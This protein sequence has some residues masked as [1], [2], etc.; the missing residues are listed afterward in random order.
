[1][2]FLDG[3]QWKDALISGSN[4][5]SNAKERING[6]NVFPVPD[7]D[8]GSNMSSTVESAVGN[9]KSLTTESIGKIAS[10]F[11]RGALLGARGN[12]GVILSQVF[13]GFS[14]AFQ[15]KEKINSIDLAKAFQFAKKYGYGSVIKPVEGTVL[16]VVKDLSEELKNTI[17]LGNNIEYTFEKIV[18]IAQKSV[19]NT[20]NL[21][22]IL[23]EVGVVDSGGE[24]LLV[25]L[26]GVLSYV[27]GSPV[28]LQQ[29]NQ[30]KK[31]S[32]L[33]LLKENEEFKQGEFGYCTEF[34]VD[35]KNPKSFDKSKF[36]QG[37]EKMKSTS[38]VIVTDEN[39]LKTHNHTKTPGKV[40][41]FAQR[42]GE[43]IKIKSE[44]MTLQANESNSLN[45]NDEVQIKENEEE[46]IEKL[47]FAVI[48]C[49]IGNGI[50]SEMKDLGS[51]FVIE[52][53]QTN[54][55]SPK[56]FISAIEK[57]KAEKIIILPNN[58]NI[59]LAAQQV[60][61]TIKNKQI[62]IIPSRTQ[63]EG[64]VSLMSFNQENSFE[65][66][67]FN[68]NEAIENVQNGQITKSLKTT[69]IRG[70]KVYEGEYLA[71]A[72]GKILGSCKSKIESVIKICDELISEDSEIISIYFGDKTTK[73][74]AEEIATYVENNYDVEIEIKDGG[75]PLYDFLI[76]VE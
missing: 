53:G 59:I 74:D 61:K 57:S 35:L 2:D 69:S 48:S 37:L 9:I 10:D 71:I 16:T 1:M 23:K 38:I 62:L 47:N 27:K 24:G 52:G 66:N 30:E 49:N 67:K 12:S 58:S 40:L 64:I 11:S 29:E 54:N 20:P 13:K 46:N 42:F 73:T 31:T 3:K 18:E 14:E 6:L 39:I 15:D 17:T 32:R 76:G 21:L 7:G 4:S 63:I 25:F 56:D 50:I 36:Q 70:V 43:F 51:T 72:N 33:N 55:P 45:K 5:L 26:K 60:A 41:T 34:I 22:P 68:M 8:T 19:E 75:Q 65:E 44:N 28:L